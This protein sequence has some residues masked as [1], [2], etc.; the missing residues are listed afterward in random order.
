MTGAVSACIVS[1]VVGP[2]GAEDSRY[3]L[4][5]FNRWGERIFNSTETE[6]AWDGTYKDKPVPDGT[7]V[8][9]L[10]YAD[11]CQSGR[12]IHRPEH[13]TLLR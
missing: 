12:M 13:V 3:E 9:V 2:F 10:R 4:S 8:Y 6:R 5:V 11:Q 1:G 7:Y